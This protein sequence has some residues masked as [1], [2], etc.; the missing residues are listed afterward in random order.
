MLSFIKTSHSLVIMTYFIDSL[1]WFTDSLLSLFSDLRF[2]IKLFFSSST[3]HWMTNS[4]PCIF[5]VYVILYSLL[6]LLH[7]TM[8]FAVHLHFGTTSEVFLPF[9]G[10]YFTVFRYCLGIP[11]FLNFSQPCSAV[12][13]YG[14]WWGIYLYTKQE[15]LEHTFQLMKKLV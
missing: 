4:I 11:H 10:Q 12:P 5:F 2:K 9:G 15:Q 14:H 1:W 13:L 7:M 6:M 3:V 8:I